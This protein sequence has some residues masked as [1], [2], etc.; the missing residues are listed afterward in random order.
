M[1]SPQATPDARGTSSANVR[2]QGTRTQVV[3]AG[4]LAGLFSRFCI[5]PLDVLKIR[6]Q[7]QYHSLC[8]P[9]NAPPHSPRKPAGVLQVAR[10]IWRHEGITGFWKGNIPAEGLYLSY[11]AAQFLAYRSMNQALDALEQNNRGSVKL[12]GTAKSFIAGAA[13]GTAATTVTYPLDLLRTRFAAQGTEKVYAGLLAS[14]QDITRH[15]GPAGFF[16]GLSA[17]VG[18]IVPY[19][20]LFFASYEA[21]KPGM[22]TIQLPF[23]S[24]DALAGILASVFS[25]SA[26]FPLDT[27]RKRLQV[28]GPNR[29]RYVGGAR[30]PEYQRGVRGTLGMIVRREGWRGLYRGLPVSLIKA[31]PAS[32]VTMWSYERALHLL[33]GLSDD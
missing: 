10:D 11:G 5:A 9:L 30:M 1:H 15:E 18:Q 21:L 17:G 13:A 25:K 16:R 19:M 27:V 7:L 4:A 26:V 28:Q 33:Q 12:P 29:A 20:G 2:Y 14:L 22:A 3:A 8:D 31:A 23:S 24:G 32:A 6:L